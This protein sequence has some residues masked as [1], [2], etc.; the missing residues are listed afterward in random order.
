MNLSDLL[1]VD[2]YNGNLNMLNHA[3]EETIWAPW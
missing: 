2:L 3:W 1:N